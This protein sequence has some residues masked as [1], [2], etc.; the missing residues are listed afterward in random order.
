MFFN[1]AWLFI[2]TL[3]AIE[4]TVTRSDEA[5][6]KV[7]FSEPVIL[8]ECTLEQKDSVIDLSPFKINRSNNSLDLKYTAKADTYS[9]YLKAFILLFIQPEKNGSL[10]LR[11][12]IPKFLK[13]NSFEDCIEDCKRWLMYSDYFIQLEE[14]AG[15]IHMQC[16]TLVDK[17]PIS[18]E[19]SAELSLSTEEAPIDEMQTK[20]IVPLQTEEVSNEDI[21]NSIVPEAIQTITVQNT[22]DSCLETKVSP[23]IAPTTV[24]TELSRSIPDKKEPVTIGQIKSAPSFKGHV[25]M[26]NKHAKDSKTNKAPIKIRI[27]SHGKKPPISKIE[28]PQKITRRR[29]KRHNLNSLTTKPPK[30]VE[31]NILWQTKHAFI[32]KIVLYGVLILTSLLNMGII[33]LL[34]K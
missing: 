30:E 1:L 23:L 31:F 4:C 15:C 6:L 27:Q 28:T 13:K 3:W 10:E 7:S 8:S 32:V 29:L 17:T 11:K 19:L 5:T 14:T 22:N 18:I 34:A 20:A 2:R 16:Y 25:V 12:K 21:L 26:R 9:N 33:Y 24:E